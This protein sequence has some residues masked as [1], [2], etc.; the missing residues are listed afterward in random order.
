MMPPS[1]PY[2]HLKQKKELAPM[3]NSLKSL[4]GATRFELTIFPLG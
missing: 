2:T 4:A 3:A 1:A